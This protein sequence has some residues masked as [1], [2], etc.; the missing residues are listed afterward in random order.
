MGGSSEGGRTGIDGRC[1]GGDG[2]AAT[3]GGDRLG[4]GEGVVRAKLG[5]SGASPGLPKNS[6][7]PDAPMAATQRI[8]TT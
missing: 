5:E 6:M 3:G 8:K 4:L 2:L 7:Y 1:C